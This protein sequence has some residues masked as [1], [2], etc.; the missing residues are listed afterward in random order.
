MRQKYHEERFTWT[1][2]TKTKV[3]V[4]AIK[5][6][7]S[8]IQGLIYCNART[9]FSFNSTRIHGAP[10]QPAPRKCASK[11]CSQ[12]QPASRQSA[13]ET[14]RPGSYQPWRQCALETMCPRDIVPR[15]QCAV[16]TMHLRENALGDIEPWKQSALGDNLPQ[17]EVWNGKN[18]VIFFYF[19]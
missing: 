3:L 12:R 14:I 7:A 4:K 8:A 5:G 15:R 13:P 16:Q 2:F 19:Y 18:F 1:N 6:F 9:N 17:S 10:R 11:Q